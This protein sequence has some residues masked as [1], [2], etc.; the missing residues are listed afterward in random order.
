MNP[1][2]DVRHQ[3]QIQ[4]DIIPTYY[5]DRNNKKGKENHP[6]RKI[7]TKQVFNEKS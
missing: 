4:H 1:L 3:I 2:Q 5:V 6:Q 7:F